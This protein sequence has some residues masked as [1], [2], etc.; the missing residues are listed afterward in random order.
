[1]IGLMVSIT[2]LPPGCER[3]QMIAK[4]ERIITD[5]ADNCQ[6]QLPVPR[7]AIERLI[8]PKARFGAFLARLREN[9]LGEGGKTMADE[10]PDVSVVETREN[11]I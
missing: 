6:P 1:M 2:G 11:R 10:K 4:L 7:S 3:F 5:I 8:S 9:R